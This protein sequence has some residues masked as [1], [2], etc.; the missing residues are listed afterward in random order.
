MNSGLYL[1]LLLY[2][3]EQ[4]FAELTRLNYSRVVRERVSPAL[5]RPAR[6]HFPKPCRLVHYMCNLLRSSWSPE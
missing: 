4:R 2:L 6:P 3:Y 5:T 1:V